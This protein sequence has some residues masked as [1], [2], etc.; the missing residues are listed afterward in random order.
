MEIMAPPNVKATNG[1][2]L[3]GQKKI[4][5]PCEYLVRHNAR[6]ETRRLLAVALNAIVMFRF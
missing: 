1:L 6:Y 5:S 4:G 2:R 3:P